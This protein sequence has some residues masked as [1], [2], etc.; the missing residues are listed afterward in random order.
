M[1]IGYDKFIV[2]ANEIV[3]VYDQASGFPSISGCVSVCEKER[4]CVLTHFYDGHCYYYQLINGV[5]FDSIFDIT[6][7][8]FYGASIAMKQLQ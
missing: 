6:V 5:M 7:I 3:S 8:D 1:T 4:K 2:D